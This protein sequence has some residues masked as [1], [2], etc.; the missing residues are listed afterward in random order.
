M[1][2]KIQRHLGVAHPNHDPSLQ[3]GNPTALRLG[4][5]WKYRWSR[6]KMEEQY[7]SITHMAGAN[8]G[9]CGVRWQSWPNRSHSD[10]PRSSHPVLW[11]SLGEGLSLGEAWHTTF[12]LSGTVTW[13]SKPAQLSTKLAS[14]GKGWWLIAQAITEGCIEPR[15]PWCPHSIPPASTPFNF[16]NQD[17][18]PQPANIPVVAEWW[19]VPRLSPCLAHQ[20]QG[21][22]WDWRPQEL[23]V[24][25]PQSPLLSSDH[26]FESDRSSASTSSSVASVSERLGGTRHPYHGW[27]PCRETGGHV[28]INL[29]VFKDEDTKDAITYQRWCWDITVYHQAGCQDHTLLPYVIHSLQ[30]Y[31][32]VLV[33]SSGMNITLDDV[34]T[35]L[36][37]HYNNVKALDALNQELF[38]LR[39]SEKETMSDWGYTFPGTSRSLQPCF[40]T[41]FCQTEWLN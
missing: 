1:D 7:T 8:C 31:P 16:H 39:M 12:T 19:E 38:Q 40:L 34:L 9:R 20:E 15:G 41:D 23:W 2:L 29:S 14:L 36:D 30:G 22:Y 32:R 10:R 27:R 5:A 21:W 4:I 3:W 25:S 33:R 6:P 17:S 28:K 11:Q 18:S 13:V 26:V 24:D 37:E 35:I